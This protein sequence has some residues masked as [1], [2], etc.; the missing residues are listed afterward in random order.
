MIASQITLLGRDSHTSCS[1]TVRRFCKGCRCG[2]SG[3]IVLSAPCCNR[4]VVALSEPATL[5]P[6]RLWS[7]TP[8][9]CF[10]RE[11]SDDSSAV[12]SCTKMAFELC[13]GTEE[14]QLQ[15]TAQNNAQAPP[16]KLAT[17]V[18]IGNSY[19]VPGN[20][21]STE[22]RDPNVEVEHNKATIPRKSLYDC[23]S[24]TFS[25]KMSLK[26]P[27]ALHRSYR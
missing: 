8:M 25:L 5:L 13:T 12:A 17:S 7:I 2:V 23:V 19:N 20:F 24:N 21:C 27:A 1:A 26:L 11:I 4:R 14:Q 18:H 22:I 3:P 9:S 6:P 15:K 10:A 16:Y